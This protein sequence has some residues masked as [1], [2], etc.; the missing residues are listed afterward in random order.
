L[1]APA[2]VP[3]FCRCRFTSDAFADV[4]VGGSLRL[5]AIVFNL[6]LQRSKEQQAER[7]VFAWAQFE[8]SK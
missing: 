4:A 1:L 5:S 8:K 2:A 3:S 6:Q 7:S